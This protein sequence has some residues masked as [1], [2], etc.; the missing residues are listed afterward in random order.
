MPLLPAALQRVSNQSA[1]ELRLFRTIILTVASVIIATK[2]VETVE[3]IG[4]VS[5]NRLMTEILSAAC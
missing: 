3:T 5:V 2:L 4:M 1:Q